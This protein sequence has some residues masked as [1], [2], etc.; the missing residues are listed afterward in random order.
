MRNYR[1]YTIPDMSDMVSLGDMSVPSIM[2]KDPNGRS[3]S[4]GISLEDASKHANGDEYIYE[5][6]KLL[7]NRSLGD[8]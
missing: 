2:I 4:I 1:G 6:A 7:I 8:F 5:T 3:I